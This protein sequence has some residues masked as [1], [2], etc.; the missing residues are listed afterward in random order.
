M[1]LRTKLALTLVVLVVPMVG[2]F[3]VFRYVKVRQDVRERMSHRVM[4]Q[5][6]PRAVQRCERRPERFRMERRRG[7]FTVYAYRRDG[8]SANPKAPAFPVELAERLEEADGRGPVTR[9]GNKIRGAVGVTG[10]ATPREAGPCARLLI[11]WHRGFGPGP[12]EV[13]RRILVQSAVATVVLLGV[14]LVAAAPMVGRIRRLIGEVESLGDGDFQVRA[15]VDTGDEIGELARAFD[16]SGERIR[17]TIAA[18]EARDEALREYV[19]NTTHD[20]AIPVSVLQHRLRKLKR[21]VDGSGEVSGELVDGALEE[22]QYVAALVSNVGA[23][24]RLESGDVRRGMHRVSLND[25]VT[26][27]ASRHEEMARQKGIEFNWATPSEPVEVEADSTLVEQAVSN[28]VQ[29][30]VQYNVD[31]GHVALVLDRQ[32]AEGGGEEF[33]IRVEDDG[34]GV[35]EEMLERLTERS[36]RD[37]E[38]RS[39]QSGGQGFGLAIARRVV[40]R[41]GWELSLANRPEGGLSVIIL[42]TSTSD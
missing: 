40:E 19:A 1:S 21:Q 4:T 7:N 38:A 42:G 22:I 32:E 23:Q 9:W 8:T 12:W 37:G 39:R 36:V 14:G 5:L 17:E 26:R 29:N 10:V 34:P 3:S 13:V 31:G 33:E 11:L 15:E 35:P 27:V 25:V 2:A 18:L 41:H 20:L 28:C 6:V 16:A 24:A 30:A